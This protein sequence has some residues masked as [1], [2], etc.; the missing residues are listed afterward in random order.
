MSDSRTDTPQT[1]FMEHY[2]NSAV[3]QAFYALRDFAGTGREFTYGAVRTSDGPGHDMTKFGNG[4]AFIVPLTVPDRY[5]P[6][7]V[8]AVANLRIICHLPGDPVTGGTLYLE[9]RLAWST[10]NGERHS[11][12]AKYNLYDI[13]ASFLADEHA[14]PEKYKLELSFD[15]DAYERGELD[16]TAAQME[17]IQNLLIENAERQMPYEAVW[18]QGYPYA[19]HEL[20]ATDQE[21]MLRYHHEVIEA[22]R[23]RQSDMLCML[24]S[25]DMFAGVG[26]EEPLQLL[27]WVK[28]RPEAQGILS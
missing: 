18:Q 24:A 21:A 1:D 23:D 6:I 20:S 9:T 5:S 17:E 13:T 12:Y 7:E 3:M 8:D 10:S 28:T 27:R 26:P 11:C 14:N 4:Y 16:P 25:N 2:R 19:D 15:I 22:A